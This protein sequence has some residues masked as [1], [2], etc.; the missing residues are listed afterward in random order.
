MGGMDDFGGG[1]MPDFN[2]PSTQT[3]EQP[4]TQ[5]TP[6]QTPQQTLPQQTLPQQGIDYGLKQKTNH[7]GFPQDRDLFGMKDLKKLQLNK[8][9]KSNKKNKRKSRVPITQSDISKLSQFLINNKQ[10]I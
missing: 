1:E 7:L 5:Q 10:V 3:M 2:Q 6:Q 8:P 4:Q 9:I